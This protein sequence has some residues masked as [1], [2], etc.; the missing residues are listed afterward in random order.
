MHHALSHDTIVGLV[1][2][3]AGAQR[4][5]ATARPRAKRSELSTGAHWVQGIAGIPQAGVPG[6]LGKM[7]LFCLTNPPVFI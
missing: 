5:L 7:P 1:A 6:L 4:A 2:R 3:T